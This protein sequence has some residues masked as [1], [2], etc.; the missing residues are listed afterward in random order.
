MYCMTV[1]LVACNYVYMY[2]AVC[3]IVSLLTMSI[4]YI[5]Y[6][7]L[8]NYLFD[9]ETSLIRQLHNPTLFECWI[10]EVL[11]YFELRRLSYYGHWWVL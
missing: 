9:D 2:L 8:Q 5:C 1:S 4:Q 6:K 10:R 7:W 3:P 11:L